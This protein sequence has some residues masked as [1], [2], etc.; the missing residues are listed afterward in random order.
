M[1]CHGSAGCPPISADRGGADRFA[2][3]YAALRRREGWIGPSGR[4]DPEGGEPRL[5]ERRLKA[6][7]E[8]AAALRREWAGRGRR[9]LIDVGSGGG[10]AAQYL[11]DADVIG[12][13]LLNAAA[14]PGEMR[15]RG[16]MRRLPIR[17]ATVDAAFYAASLHYAPIE[18]SIREA[19][20]VLRPG[21]VIIAVDS[22]IYRDRAAQEQAKARSAKY[23]A[24]AGFP[25][26]ADHYHPIDVTALRAA[27]AGAGFEVRLLDAG[28]RAG[29]WWE[30][31]RKS[32]RFSIL[33]ARYP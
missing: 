15:V 19:A 28:Q 10:W 18:D 2:S 5:W 31:L 16:D 32:R 17:D 8:A 7:S 30:R 33:V 11:P 1:R 12:I 24:A 27:L 3:Q 29:R 26:L 4:E 13:D 25:D 6:V 20:R 21:G 14:R 23:Y 22:P 9:L